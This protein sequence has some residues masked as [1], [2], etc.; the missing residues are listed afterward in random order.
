[1]NCACF[2]YISVKKM[3]I[4]KNAQTFMKWVVSFMHANAYRMNRD[5]VNMLIAFKVFSSFLFSICVKICV[6]DQFLVLIL[7]VG[8]VAIVDE[9]HRSAYGTQLFCLYTWYLWAND[10]I[11]YSNRALYASLLMLCCA[12]LCCV[13]SFIIFLCDVFL[14]PSLK[15]KKARRL[16]TQQRQLATDNIEPERY[17]F[18]PLFSLSHLICAKIS[19]HDLGFCRSKCEYTFF[20]SVSPSKVSRKHQTEV[21]KQNRKKN[22]LS[23]RSLLKIALQTNQAK[24]YW[25]Q[26]KTSYPENTNTDH[27]MKMLLLL[28]H[29]PDE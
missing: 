16:F 1:M 26:Q 27:K 9:R 5:K 15:M 28:L 19:F 2:V 29:T 4:G 24:I 8:A 25:K 6:V 3:K 7:F 23:V 22:A 11:L 14:S 12:V 17:A 20:L 21:K 10:E 13:W 18:H